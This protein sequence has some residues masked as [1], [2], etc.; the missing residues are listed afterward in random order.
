MPDPSTL[1]DT[2]EVPKPP[3]PPPS[4]MARAFTIDFF[5]LPRSIRERVYE[6]VDRD[7]RFSLEAKEERQELYRT[8][9]HD[10]PAAL[11]RF[12]PY[13]LLRSSA[14]LRN[15]ILARFQHVHFHIN[16]HWLGGPPCLESIIGGENLAW[17]SAN[18]GQPAEIHRLNVDGMG[19]LPMTIEA[20]PDLFMYEEVD[21]RVMN[22]ARRQVW[23]AG[24][25]WL[26][27]MLGSRVFADHFG[28]F[29]S[30]LSENLKASIEE[31]G[32]KGLS[33]K[34]LD[35][36]L[37]SVYAFSLEMDARG[38]QMQLARKRKDRGR[39]ASRKRHKPAQQAL[40]ERMEA[41]RKVAEKKRMLQDVLKL[42]EP[43]E[44]NAAEKEPDSPGTP[45]AKGGNQDED[46]RLTRMRI[47][48]PS[49]GLEASKAEDLDECGEGVEI[50]D[51]TGF[52]DD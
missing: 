31:R 10:Q 18:P 3:P 32:G 14:R 2:A 12:K 27:P 6:F 44:G 37:K 29:R 13:A 15:E 33:V 51:L 26:V 46:N 47:W 25:R 9:K 42:Y 38:H 7:K 39:S 30:A 16:V 36:L 35:L 5:A 24:V 41:E 45:A 34:E 48:S 21:V 8:D 22:V 19:V 17:L 20:E 28:K 40:R 52:D 1:S 23:K 4:D 50:V 49:R 11:K 43:G